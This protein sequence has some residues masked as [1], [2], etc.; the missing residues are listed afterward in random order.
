VQ[1]LDGVERPDPLL[2]L[3]SI[4]LGEVDMDVVVGNVPGDD[5]A[6]RRDVQNGRVVGVGVAD[7]NGNQ[8]GALELEA[9]TI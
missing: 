6:D 3:L 2:S 4:R 9:G 5:Q 7:L 8:L 1:R